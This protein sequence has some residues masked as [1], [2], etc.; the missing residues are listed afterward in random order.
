[1]G[2]I[3]LGCRQYMRSM[4]EV[5]HKTRSTALMAINKRVFSSYESVTEMLKPNAKSPWGNHIAI[6]HIT[7]PASSD[8]DFSNPLDFVWEAQKII[9]RKRSSIGV[10][11]TGWLLNSIHKLRGP[12]VNIIYIPYILYI[13]KRKKKLY[14]YFICSEK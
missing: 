12:K 2:T 14:S 9:R 11:L 10:Y 3:F 13:A 4:G 5:K 6:L 7:L 8:S 1:M